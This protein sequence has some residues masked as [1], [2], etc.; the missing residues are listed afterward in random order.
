MTR[1]IFYSLSLHIKEQ[2]VHQKKL[3]S[4]VI[5]QFLFLLFPIIGFAQEEKYKLTLAEAIQFAKTQ[6]KSV[7]ATQIEESAVAAD[8]K[9]V[10][11]AALPVINTGTSYQRFSGLTLF[12][13]GLSNSRTEQRKPSSN[14]ANLG[15][16]VLFNIYSGGKQKALQEEQNSRLKLATLN[17]L[18]TS[19]NIAFQTASQYLDL[20]KL[21][22]LKKFILDQLKRSQ[23]RLSNIN[24]LYKN[25]KVTKSDLLRAQVTLSNVE[26]SLQQTQNDISIA[27]EK[28]D[29]LMNIPDSVIISPIDS[30]G[31]TKPE[32]KSLLPFVEGIE[33]SSFGV[34]KTAENV[35]LQRARV[36]A[37][38]SNNLP[39]LSFYS[40]YG[41]NY[42]NYLFFPPVDQAYSIGFVGLKL[43]YN[44]SSIY[45]NKD[46]LVAAKLR[47]K[48]LE[49][50]HEAHSDNIR[51]EIKSYYIKYGEALNRI[52]VNEEAV[53]Q[54][55]VNYGIVNSRYLNQLS[56]LTDLLDADN[57]YQESRLNL[58]KAQT[59]ALTIY[60]HILYTS[61][62]L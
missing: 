43:Q 55:K 34:Q 2:A 61:G 58:V 4:S 10:Y 18:D 12:T 13:D 53:E 27:N 15:I 5:W 7:Q 21:Y 6:N 26:L 25:Q 22:E 47:V 50:E 32:I 31:I 39:S 20:V 60:Y 54:A 41:L 38:R 36:K 33:R 16:D 1:S 62:N 19:G 52:S 17:S 11:K 44:I 24:S 23:A 35:E 28:L 46:K 45:Q 9:D 37:V 59:D 49:T 40:A 30:A 56:L 57:L 42:P 8:R 29:I 51:A 14:S 3:F 48:E